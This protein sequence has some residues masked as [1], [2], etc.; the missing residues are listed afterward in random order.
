MAR[1]Q[2][3]GL[4]IEY[5]LLGPKDAPAIVLTPGGRFA[6]DS[7]GL[8]ELA[9]VLAAG[10]RRVL[11]WDR[12]NCGA[13]D[14][15]FGGKSESDLQARTLIE[16]IRAL[17][18]GPTAVAAGSGGSRVSLIAAAR[19]PEAV[20]H[21][22]VWWISG[23]ALSLISL[24]AYYCVGSAIAA[25]RGG[26]AAVADSPGWAEQIQ[27]NPKNRDILLAQDPER[28]IETMER[29]AL[30]YMPNEASPV[31]G[32]S[33]ESFVRL[34]MPVLVYRSGKSDLSHTRRTSEWVHELIPH[35]ELREPPWPDEEWNNR[36]GYA[37]KH[38]SGHFAGWPALAP[39][40]LDFTSRP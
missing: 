37:M 24:A 7:P 17:E 11:L 20:S 28:F 32:M 2:I 33:P 21:L 29:W 40:I 22:I 31:P 13:S 12:P 27:R 10:G 6:K 4:G 15:S 38:G 35:S 5:E 23:G 34:R 36:S 9:R 14:I 8:P 16:L 19:D 26:M 1:I 18:L 30:A 25:S 39:A 3:S